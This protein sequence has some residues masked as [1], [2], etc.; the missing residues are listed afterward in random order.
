ML[1]WLTELLAKDIRGFNVFGY[2]T[3]RAVLSCMTALLILPKRPP[4][5]C[6]RMYAFRLRS[7]PSL[8]SFSLLLITVKFPHPR[9]PS[10]PRPNA[11][12]TLDYCSK[13]LSGQ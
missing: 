5:E 3:L 13:R 10:N 9:T 11:H 12:S 7:A 1:L 8:S 2:L 6:A 4:Q